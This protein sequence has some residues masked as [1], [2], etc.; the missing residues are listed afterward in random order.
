MKRKIGLS[1]LGVALGALVGCP[2]SPTDPGGSGSA[3]SQ[4]QGNDPT[5][6]TSPASAPPPHNPKPDA[7]GP[8]GPAP[9]PSAPRDDGRDWVGSWKSPRCGARTYAREVTFTAEGTVSGNELVS[10]CPPNVDCVWSGI[11]SWKGTYK[12]AAGTLSLTVT[13][14]GAAKVTLPSSLRWDA[15]RGALVED[16]DGDACAYHR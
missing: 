12:E 14:D 8:D 15:G 13:P 11:V 7:S 2:K 16:P 5:A 6:P 4:D 9:S 3:T 10:P 1:L